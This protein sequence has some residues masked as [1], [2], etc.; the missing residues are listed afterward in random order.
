MA[1]RITLGQ[2]EEQIGRLSNREKLELAGRILKQVADEDRSDAPKPDIE[3]RPDAGV[4][5]IGGVRVP[6]RQG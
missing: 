3:V 2:L 5:I 1:D 6:M 4:V